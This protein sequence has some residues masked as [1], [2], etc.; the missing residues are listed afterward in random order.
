MQF[1]IIYLH[2][3]KTAGTSFRMSAEQYFGPDQVLND[4]GEESPNTSE[5]IRAVSYTHLTL[6]TIC[7]V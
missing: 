1:P 3:P 4:Y 6:P 5:D 7:S 2:I